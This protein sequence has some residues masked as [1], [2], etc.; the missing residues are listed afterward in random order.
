MIA[1]A[2]RKI[3]RNGNLSENVIAPLRMAP[4]YGVFVVIELAGLVE[5]VVGNTDL[6]Y[7]VK[8][9]DIVNMLNLVFILAELSRQHSG[10]L[11]DTE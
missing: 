8:K 10:I 9:G 5:Y 3:R 11:R 2:E 4:H 6:S 1:R 7:I